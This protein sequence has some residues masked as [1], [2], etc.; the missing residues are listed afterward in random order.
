MDLSRRLCRIGFEALSCGTAQLAGET[1]NDCLFEKA[2]L[3]LRFVDRFR[4]T[5]LILER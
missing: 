1:V 3:Y 4:M 2:D 5:G